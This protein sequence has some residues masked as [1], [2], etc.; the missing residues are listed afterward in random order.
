MSIE[1]RLTAGGAAWRESQ[2][3]VTMSPLSEVRR[4]PARWLP[5]TA[6][7]ATVA[8][9]IGASL[10]VSRDDSP[11]PLASDVVP[12]KQLAPAAD[13]VAAPS[14][15]FE[16]PSFGV[17]RPGPCQASDVEV[18]LTAKGTGQSVDGQL[19]LALRTSAGP[20]VLGS[21]DPV[22]AF[23]GPA[24]G[25]V[26]PPSVFAGH[27]AGKTQPRLRDLI[28][29]TRAEPVM[30]PFT[31]A[32]VNCV[33]T[34]G[35]VISQLDGMQY[36]KYAL[37]FVAS[38]PSATVPV[39]CDQDVAREAGE[40]TLGIPHVEGGP[41]G[42][43]PGD[44]SG[45]EVSLELPSRVPLDVLSFVARLHNPTNE[46]VSLR[47]CPDYALAVTWEEA[48]RD[49][50]PSGVG[51]LN[52]ENAPE[53]VPAGGTV[54]FEMQTGIDARDPQSDV[55]VTWGIA[56]PDLSEA[57]TSFIATVPSPA[58]TPSP[59][60]RDPGTTTSLRADLDEDGR[61]DVV[62]VVH[63]TFTRLL[64]DRAVGVDPAPVGF[65]PDGAWS[66]RGILPLDGP[67]GLLLT[68]PGSAGTIVYRLSAG[69]LS[70][71]A[72]REGAPLKLSFRYGPDGVQRGIRCEAT[73]LALW[74]AEAIRRPD[75]T[76]TVRETVGALSITGDV[77]T[78]TAP[79]LI[80]G[81]PGPFSEEEA[82]ERARADAA[83]YCPGLDAAGFAREL[84]RAE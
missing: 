16:G 5:L 43:L 45:L 22:L 82:L 55:T 10:L 14:V 7:A 24:D 61:P 36:G 11:A 53:A 6:A 29:R 64:V 21:G 84:Q 17:M 49:V 12:W 3:P 13:D 78:L 80:P 41:S 56:G 73:G 77:G 37:A 20:C 33:V 51:R 35:L 28:L 74:S 48:G 57:T 26:S 50:T 44:R 25:Q 31:W 39:P 2:P 34:D 72:D 67:D 19:R 70:L 9:V 83:T 59:D 38:F 15:P 68:G 79:T 1:G 52:C 75:G 27:A 40:L 76:W 66:L 8:V 65:G 4:K 54:A 71:V 58:V 18:T 42:R 47:P 30:V 81:P 23:T 69:D 60:R 63:D 62:T 46:A 32:G